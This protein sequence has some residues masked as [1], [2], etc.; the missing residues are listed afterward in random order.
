LLKFSDK[1]NIHFLTKILL[2]YC[3]LSDLTIGEC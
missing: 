1:Y 3:T 2:S